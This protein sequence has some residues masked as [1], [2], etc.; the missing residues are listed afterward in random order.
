[1]LEHSPGTYNGYCAFPD[2]IDL[3]KNPLC[4]F[5]IEGIKTVCDSLDP[6][7][8]P[9]EPEVACLPV[10]V[11]GPEG[12]ELCV[13]ALTLVQGFCKVFVALGIPVIEATV[14]APP[15]STVDVQISVTDL[16]DGYSL[17]DTVSIMDTGVETLINLGL[18]VVLGPWVGELHADTV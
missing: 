13:A 12:Y 11:T 1:L 14:C 10:F 2:G 8:V 9:L 7:A 17:G 4:D 5:G 6:M 16:F 3:S 15:P 18:Y